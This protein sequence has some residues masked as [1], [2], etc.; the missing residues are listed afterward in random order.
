ML[1]VADGPEGLFTVADA[2]LVKVPIEIFPTPVPPVPVSKSVAH[3]LPFE[4]I[5]RLNPE[6]AERSAADL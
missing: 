1:I 5:P 2:P 6:F 4:S 3:M